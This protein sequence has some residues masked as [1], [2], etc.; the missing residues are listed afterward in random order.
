MDET[1]LDTASWMIEPPSAGSVE[2]LV[3][4]FP[5]PLDHGLLLRALGV[6]RPDG[7]SVEG[8]IEVAGDETR[9]LF[10]PDEPWRAG[11]YRLDALSVLE[12]LAG[13][14]IGKLFE[15]DVFEQIDD[16]QQE[17]SYTLPFLV[18]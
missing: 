8:R 9:W 13:N 7:E 18:K 16:P 15:V 14:Q 5:E 10:A 3:V 4:T 17:E 6:S 12:D 11:T 2:P 1:P